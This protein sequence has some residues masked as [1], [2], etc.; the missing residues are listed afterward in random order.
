M[1]VSRPAQPEEPLERGRLRELV[2][3]PPRAHHGV[4]RPIYQRGLLERFLDWFDKYVKHASTLA[5]H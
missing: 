3:A 5:A 4:R 1:N 2:A